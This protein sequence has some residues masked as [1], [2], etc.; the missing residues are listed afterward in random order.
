MYE[1]QISKSTETNALELRPS[2]LCFTKF[3]ILVHAEDWEKLLK[4]MK[5]K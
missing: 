4:Y 3:S 2:N 5:G 1:V